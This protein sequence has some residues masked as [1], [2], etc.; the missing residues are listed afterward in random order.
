MQN[1]VKF[2]PGIGELVFDL[3]DFVNNVYSQLMSFKTIHQKR[4]RFK[5]YSAKIEQYMKNNISFYA[6][7]LL[8]VY[9]IYN[10]NIDSPKNIEGNIFLNLSEEQKNDYDYMMQVNFL[11]N[12]FDSFERDMLYY[13]GK[14]F[15]IPLKW[16]NILSMY[17]EFLELNKGF[18]NTKMTSDLKLPE[19]LRNIKFSCNIN[20]LIKQVISKKDLELLSDVAEFGE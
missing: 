6:G 11:E 9:F 1:S 10:S 14:N 2:D 12:Y 15:T 5:M 16:K 19:K 20:N 7:C 8:W 3:N 4:A 17:S 18:T 13:T